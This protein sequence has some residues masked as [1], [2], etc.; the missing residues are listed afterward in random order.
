MQTEIYEEL[1]H[2]LDS[3]LENNDMPENTAAFNFN[4]YEES[5][6]DSVCGI[7]LIAADRF[8]PEN[9]DDW[10][11]CEAWSS[12]EDIFCVST[13]DEDDSSWQG[14]QKLITEM[15][16]EYLENGKY[17]NILTAATAVGVGFVDGD[18]DII[19]RNDEN[20]EN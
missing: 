2:W 3:L 15:I 18:I 1:S 4:L 13:A 16:R 10:A 19:Y 20:S 17:G 14:A 7:Q 5:E 8:D 9:G 11:C 6:E 12:E